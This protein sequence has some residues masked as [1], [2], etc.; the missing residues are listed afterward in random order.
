MSNELNQPLVADFLYLIGC[1]LHQL[2]PDAERVAGMDME[3]LYRLAKSQTLTAIT[4]MGLEPALTEEQRSS[5]LMVKW[6]QRKDRAIRK[7][8]LL[9]TARAE[10]CARMEDAGIWY[11][12]LKGSL[13]KDLYPR[14]GMRQM[15]DNDILYDETREDDLLTI[16]TEL[17][18]QPES[19]GRGV[20][21]VYQKP[22]VYNFEMHRALFG[23]TGQ[24]FEA[25]YQNVKDR[26]L[27]AEGHT[28]AYRFSDEDFY[29]YVTAHAYKHYANCGTGLR[30]L[31]DTYVYL[32]A[33]ASGMDWVY[34]RR[35]LAALGLA[36]FEEQARTL[37]DKLFAAPLTEDLLTDADREMLAYCLGSGTYGTMETMVGNRLQE[38]QG[39][40]GKVTR[41]TKWRYYWSRFYPSREFCRVN[42]PFVARWWIIKPFWAVFRLGR[43]LVRNRK[44][45]GREI[46]I[47]QRKGEGAGGTANASEENRA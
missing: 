36:A 4:Y 35:E 1:A 2:P 29:V 12:P 15:A 7:N 41:R 13:L 31:A 45:I 8:L 46:R 6:R 43:G 19:V 47:V 34:L 38:M 32:T 44:A 30:F 42:Y 33:R 26:L 39:A 14:V 23:S 17:G 27:P 10:I 5:E 37:A 18:Y 9:D 40:D 28:C 22:P 24:Q 11:M 3:R 25:Y 16:M 21:D 20:H